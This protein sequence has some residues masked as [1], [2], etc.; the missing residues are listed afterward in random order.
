MEGALGLVCYHLP[1]YGAKLSIISDQ[2]LAHGL[3]RFRVAH[4]PYCELFELTE[5][6]ELSHKGVELMNVRFGG[7]M[8]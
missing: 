8:K 6:F 1:D 4:T 3:K 5:G 7:S 2:F